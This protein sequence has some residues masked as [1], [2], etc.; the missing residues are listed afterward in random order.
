MSML[1]RPPHLLRPGWLIFLL[2]W[3]LSACLAPPPATPAAPTPTLPPPPTFTPPVAA[4]PTPAFPAASLTITQPRPGDVL[5]IATPVLVTGEGEGLFEGTLVVQAQD[6]EGH[7][8]LEVPVTLEGEEVGVGG[9]GVWSTLLDL[10]H[11]PAGTTGWIIA[12]STSPKD[13]SRVAEAR[14]KVTF[15]R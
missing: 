13:G 8:L 9:H 6:A 2:A 15:G 12:F 11:A 3:V 10:S 4:T 1:S 5:D 14:V 7:P